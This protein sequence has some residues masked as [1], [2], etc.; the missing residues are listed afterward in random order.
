MVD[1]GR[2]R[3]AG[4]RIPHARRTAVVSG[5]EVFSV[6]AE[7]RSLDLRAVVESGEKEFACF[8][9]PKVGFGFVFAERKD[10][11]PIRPLEEAQDFVR[12]LDAAD[13]LPRGHI[14][15][16]CRSHRTRGEPV[17]ARIQRSHG[18]ARIM[19]QRRA[20]GLARG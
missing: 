18:A 20:Y 12:L 6:R 7:I 9:T 10:R 11:T 5:D 1:G 15:H 17:A 4:D 8:R 19:F 2:D 3:H 13:L 14:P 16:L